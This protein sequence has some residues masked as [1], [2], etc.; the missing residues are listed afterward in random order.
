MQNLDHKFGAI[1]AG[2]IGTVLRE[3]REALDLTPQEVSEATHLR[4]GYIRAIEQLNSEALPT[5]GYALG[6][7]RTYAK[8]LGLDADN[9]VK[10]YKADIEAPEDIRVRSG[11]RFV[12]THSIKLPRAFVPA[13]GVVGFAVMLGVWYGSANSIQAASPTAFNAPVVESLTD[14]GA[15]KAE[16]TIDPN[17]VTLRANAPSWVQIKDGRGKTVI[18]RIFVTG[19]TY[20]ALRGSDLKFSVRDAGAVDVFIG[21]DNLG[22]LGEAG[23]PLKNVPFPR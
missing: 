11:P 2:H 14:S 1:G 16:K 3:A 10:R 13:L 19:E 23:Q 7:V 12:P 6:Y 9:V 4:V 15:A 17:L 18:S 5:L 22:A 20:S 21:E 8:F